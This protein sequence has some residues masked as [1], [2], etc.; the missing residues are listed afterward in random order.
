MSYETQY[1]G[2]DIGASLIVSQNYLN[3]LI[4]K[5]TTLDM[6]IY[7]NQKY[8]EALEKRI[9]SL[10]DNSPYSN[11]LHIESQYENMRTIKESQGNMMEIGTIIALLLLLVGVLNYA[12]T[13]ASSI[14]N[15]KLTFSV[16][17]SIGMSR[18][19]I[20][21]LLIREG[22]LY[23]LSSV[24]IT[25]TIGSAITYVCFQYMNYMGIPFKVP[26]ISLIS[27]I[28][29]VMLICTIAPLLSYK[30]LAGNRSIVERLRDYE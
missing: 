16:M 7:Y 15:R 17:E 18:K 19:Q 22:V 8:D 3:S 20:N 24:F 23:A 26:G 25:L 5:P 1:S 10:V 4:S 28:I 29:L 13:I 9:T 21:Q 14:Q 2:R 27:A 6:Y 12:N 11:D 30:K